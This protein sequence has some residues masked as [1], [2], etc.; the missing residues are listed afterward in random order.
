MNPIPPATN[1]L[2][3]ESLIPRA[4]DGTRRLYMESVEYGCGLYLETAR[5]MNTRSKRGEI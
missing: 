3:I 4:L 2:R 5:I 1:T